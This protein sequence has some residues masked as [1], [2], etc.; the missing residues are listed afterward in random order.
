MAASSTAARNTRQYRRPTV[1]LIADDEGVMGAARSIEGFDIVAALD[2]VSDLLVRYGGHSQAAGLTVKPGMIDEFRRRLK[3]IADEA[4][5]PEL[6]VPV[7]EID[8][9]LQGDEVNLDLLNELSELE[10]YGMGNPYPVFSIRK[11]KVREHGR[12]GANGSHLK[13]RVS[14]NGTATLNAIGWGLG[15]LDEDIGR[16]HLVDMAV[17]LEFNFWQDKQSLQLQVIDIKPS[18]V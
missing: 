12:V 17:Q 1:L 5:S 15:Y 6:L 4:I 9:E 13:L 8:A 2:K 11:M 18:S 3:E 16:Y 10:P 14:Q 7:V